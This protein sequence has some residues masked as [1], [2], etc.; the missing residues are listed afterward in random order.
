M[1]GQQSAPLTRSAKETVIE[2]VER[3]PAFAVTL[4]DEGAALTLNGECESV[5][6]ILSDLVNAN[7]G[8]EPHAVLIHDPFCRTRERVATK[9]RIP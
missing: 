1:S 7:V 8:F 2:R 5:R 4:L 9:V 3:D 6:L